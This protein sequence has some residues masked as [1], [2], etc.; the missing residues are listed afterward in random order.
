MLWLVL[1]AIAGA[2]VIVLFIVLF[3]DVISRVIKKKKL[4]IFLD[5]Y[6]MISLGMSKQQ[7]VNLLGNKYTQSA[8][9]DTETLSWSCNTNT[10]IQRE[11]Y[12][13]LEAKRI[14]IVVF[15]NNQVVSYNLQ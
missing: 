6:R 7:I 2:L 15:S 5:N 10:A 13:K 3:I 11:L 12:S 9:I 1:F 14:I 8:T 4:S